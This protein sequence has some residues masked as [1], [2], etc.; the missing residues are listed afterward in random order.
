MAAKTYLDDTC[1]WSAVG[2]SV[3]DNAFLAA[4]PV[5]DYW[6]TSSSI[7]PNTEYGGTWEKVTDKFI[8]ASG[9]K[10]VGDTGGS[11]TVTLTVDQIPSH[12]HGVP[13]YRDDGTSKNRLLK[14]GSGVSSVSS[15]ATGGVS[16][17]TTCPRTWLRIVGTVLHKSDYIISNYGGDTTIN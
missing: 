13:A 6:W 14:L 5:G 16:H 1:A 3:D 12:S 17:T 2:S 4:H 11:E 9:S 8:Y 7:D 10:S 15:D